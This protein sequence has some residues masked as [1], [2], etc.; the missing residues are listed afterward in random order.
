M[1]PRIETL[2]SS[3][4]LPVAH[5]M[6]VPPRRI[7]GVLVIER[8]GSWN[9]PNHLLRHSNG[10]HPGDRRKFDFAGMMCLAL[11]IVILTGISRILVCLE[12]ELSQAAAF[13]SARRSS[14]VGNWW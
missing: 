12:C 14:H 5:P 4:S 1:P 9:L 11:G 7:D 6:R 10:T 2:C 3:N 8:N 13:Q